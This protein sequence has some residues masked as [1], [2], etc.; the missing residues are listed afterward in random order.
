MFYSIRHV[1]NVVMFIAY[2]IIRIGNYV[3]RV[4]V[5][6]CSAVRSYCVDVLIVLCQLWI[7]LFAFRILFSQVRV[8]HYLTVVAWYWQQI[9][10]HGGLKSRRKSFACICKFDFITT[11][12]SY[13]Y[14]DSQDSALYCVESLYN[15]TTTTFIRTKTEKLFEQDSW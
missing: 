15:T 5:Q 4:T 1:S 2:S 6:C 13:F 8:I 10:Q 14:S 12:F 11:K 9:V 3:S 7:L